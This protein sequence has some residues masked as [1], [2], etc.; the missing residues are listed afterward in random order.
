MARKS[1]QAARKAQEAR[2]GAFALA[3]VA[4]AFLALLGAAYQA[5]KA[6]GVTVSHSLAL[7]G[8]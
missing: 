4:L 6:A 1:P 8:L 3:S 2:R 7:W 5:D